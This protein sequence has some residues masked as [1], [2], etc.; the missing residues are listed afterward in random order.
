[1]LEQ[2]LPST[3]VFVEAFRDDPGAVLFPQ[4]EA[5]IA[6]AAQRRRRE[7]A[8]VRA[9]AHAALAQLGEPPAPIIPDA[10][11]APRWPDGV[12]GS[13]VHCAGYRAAGVARS[14]VV[15]ALGFDAER[16]EPLPDGVLDAIARAAERNRIAEL[17]VINPAVC[18]DRLLFCAKE[19]VYKTWFPLTGRWLDFDAA[20]VIIDPTG[21]GFTARLLVSGPVVAGSPMSMLHGRWLADRELVAAAITV[22]ARTVPARNPGAG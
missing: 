11:G 10:Q 14:R 1:M 5:V 2:I 17:A 9:C 6:R 20:D 7:F 16:N 4:E 8:T 18:W 21:G 13:M 3:V 15:A 22:P 19:S 12:V